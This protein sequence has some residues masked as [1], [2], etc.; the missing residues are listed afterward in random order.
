MQTPLL[1]CTIVYYK[2]KTMYIVKITEIL[3]TYLWKMTVDYMLRT[4]YNISKLR[5]RNK[6]SE[7]GREYRKRE[8][9]STA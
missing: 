8:S 1:L 4:W 2:I 5:E 7:C 9:K 6:I 3:R